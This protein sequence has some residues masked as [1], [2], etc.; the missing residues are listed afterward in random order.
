MRWTKLFDNYKEPQ[1]ED[2]LQK[3]RSLAEEAI[4]LEQALDSLAEEAK[5]LSEGKNEILQS[6]LPNLMADNG[7]SS[8]EL[9]NGQKISIKEV[10]N[11]T[12][13]KDEIGKN[14]LF[15]WLVSEDAA[16]I[17]KTE[18]SIAFGKT[19]H[20]LAIDTMT[21]LQER[22]LPAVCKTGVH[23][24]TFNAFLR[25]R[26]EKGEKLPSEDLC[27]TYIGKIAKIK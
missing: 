6:E 2:A 13:P 24:Q 25:E 3:T 11:G 23:G 19:E 7:M 10:V 5:Q 9:E 15:D 18:V 14:R 4:A 20:N 21:S 26:I 16:D 1:S 8:F 27:K 17:I 12:V 22:G